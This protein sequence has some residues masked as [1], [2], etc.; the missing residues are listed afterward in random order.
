MKKRLF[1]LIFTFLLQASTFSNLTKAQN[2]TFSDVP[3]TAWYFQPV[4]NGVT[5]KYIS[6][7]QTYRPE[8]KLRRSEIA[9]MLT[10]FGGFNLSSDTPISFKDVSEPEWYAPFVKTLVSNG[11]IKG[12]LDENG[13]ATGY[14]GPADF[15]TRNQVA[16]LLNRILNLKI[17]LPATSN[18]KDLPPS[19]W[20]YNDVMILTEIGII[21]GYKDNTYRGNTLINRAEIASLLNKAY[22][23]LETSPDSN[24]TPSNITEEK[25]LINEPIAFTGPDGLTL[26]GRIFKPQGPGP[27]PAVVFMHGCSGLLTGSSRTDFLASQYLW[28]GEKMAQE[29]KTVA[30]FVDSF[31]ARNIPEVCGDGTILS[32][33]IERPKDA[34]AG[35]TYLRT[36]NYVKPNK[37]GLMGWSNGGSAVLSAMAKNNNP[38]TVPSIGGFITAIAEYPGCGLRSNYGTDYFTVSNRGTYLPYAPLIILAAEKDTTAPPTPRCINLVDQAKSL[39]ASDKTGNPIMLNIYEGAEHSFDGA[40]AETAS[41][42]DLMAQEASRNVIRSHFRSYLG[43]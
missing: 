13:N 33:V 34:Y 4:E 6:P 5:R 40:K 25:T 42:A 7:A 8:D 36:L 35:L 22:L 28:W 39:G 1:L 31:T 2:Q 15:V 3:T 41:P 11:I 9:K 14:F 20:A 30:L 16:S 18:F 32:E 43:G 37:I 26:T 21:Q 17:E 23:Y 24:Q 27:F 38:V 19:D 29:D 10:I 12:Y